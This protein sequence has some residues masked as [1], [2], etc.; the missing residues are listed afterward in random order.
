M[1]NS[2]SELFYMLSPLIENISGFVKFLREYHLLL[3]TKRRK[4]GKIAGHTIYG[5]LDTAYVHLSPSAKGGTKVEGMNGNDAS[6]SDETRY[7]SM[8]FGM[9]LTKDFYW[10]Y[11][12]DLTKTLQYNMVNHSRYTPG[13]SFSSMFCWNH[14]LL[15]EFYQKL[16]GDT[17]LGAN[18]D[19]LPWILPLIHGYYAQTSRFC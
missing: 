14:F 7:Q 6:T 1:R 3:I 12:Y 4:V 5:V 16:H 13:K 19:C 8:F 18:E 17:P 2:R 10:S 11:T 9:D 15:K